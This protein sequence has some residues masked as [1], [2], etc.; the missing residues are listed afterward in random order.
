MQ[1]T[2]VLFDMTSVILNSWKLN[3]E[4]NWLQ[5]NK[6]S[7]LFNLLPNHQS[8]YCLIHLCNYS[9]LLNVKSTTKT[10][11]IV[12][13]YTYNLST[14]SHN[15]KPAHLTSAPPA[16]RQTISHLSCS[17]N[18]LGFPCMSPRSRCRCRRGRYCLKC[19]I[20]QII[21]FRTKSRYILKLSH[22]MVYYDIFTLPT[23]PLQ[24]ICW[25]RVWLEYR[26]TWWTVEWLKQTPIYSPYPPLP[27]NQPVGIIRWTH[28]SDW[29]V[30]APDEQWN[31]WHKS[32][33]THDEAHLSGACAAQL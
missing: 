1:S 6:L 23:P 9:E 32:K 27:S 11:R 28:T 8:V 17:V 24:P 10:W 25:D 30:V 29:N 13:L 20:S 15:V 4:R 16:V 7:K 33:H 5:I 12:R 2:H 21:F 18:V 3:T 22:G 31:G 19:L 14:F 26:Y